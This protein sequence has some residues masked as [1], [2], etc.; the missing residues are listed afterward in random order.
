MKIIA[1]ALRAVFV[2]GRPESPAVV[3][4]HGFGA[5]AMDLAS[6]SSLAP[7]LNWYFPEAPLALGPG[8]YAWFPLVAEELARLKS[9]GRNI[10]F[11]DVVPPGLSQS[12]NALS[13]FIAEAN[14]ASN[15][16]LGGF[17]QGGMLAIDAYMRMEKSPL[18]LA[19]LSSSLVCREQWQELAQNRAG[20]SFFQSHG[21]MDQ[22]LPFSRAKKLESLLTGAGMQGALLDFAGGHEIPR[23]V[24]LAL[25]DYLRG[26]SSAQAI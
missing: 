8:S 13:D 7:E 14:I 1:G 21:T 26:L 17:S 20:K 22:V 2:P 19:V 3:L 10:E 16:I 5:N 25:S 11:E 4:C 23:G 12:R 9:L 24:S 6:L 15:L 18:G